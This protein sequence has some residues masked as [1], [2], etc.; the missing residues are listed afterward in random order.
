MQ[1]YKGGSFTVYQELRIVFWNCTSF[2][3]FAL[4][5]S[6]TTDCSAV[7]VYRTPPW[8]PYH[9]SNYAAHA[10]TCSSLPFLAE[11]YLCCA[12]KHPSQFE[13]RP[14]Q[15]WTATLCEVWRFMVTLETASLHDTP[16]TVEQTQCDVA[17]RSIRHC[18][19]AADR[20]GRMCD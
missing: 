6:T 9:R 4:Y 14:E 8:E 18:R 10:D 15:S 20:T 16:D 12:L 19:A 7:A 11:L 13:L 17:V 5:F 1:T 3:Y 2:N